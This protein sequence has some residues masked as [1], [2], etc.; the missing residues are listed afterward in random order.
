[1]KDIVK[2][3]M[4]NNVHQRGMRLWMRSSQLI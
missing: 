3:I 1:M 4:Y 2:S